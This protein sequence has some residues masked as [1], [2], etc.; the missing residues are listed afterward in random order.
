MTPAH[1]MTP[2]DFDALVLERLLGDDCPNIT[3]TLDGAAGAMKL[4]SSELE[5]LGRL[6]ERLV[7]VIERHNAG[8]HGKD[9]L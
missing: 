2:E 5:E 7:G 3:A 9:T 1:R 4:D 8:P 6:R